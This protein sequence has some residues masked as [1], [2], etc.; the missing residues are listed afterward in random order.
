MA[1]PVELL[2]KALEILADPANYKDV[3]DAIPLAPWQIA[4]A[5]LAQF[6]KH[7]QEEGFDAQVLHRGCQGSA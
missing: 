7:G 5:A 2:V 4:Q 3:K 1:E 6:E